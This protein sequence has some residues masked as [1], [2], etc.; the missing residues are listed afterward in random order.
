MKKFILLAAWF[1]TIASF[2][3]KTI[4]VDDFTTKPTFAAKAALIG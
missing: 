2:A 1:L 3:Q 4:T